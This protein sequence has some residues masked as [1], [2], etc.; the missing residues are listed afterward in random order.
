[1]EEKNMIRFVYGA[2]GGEYTNLDVNSIA[3]TQA[4]FH[5]LNGIFG[6]AVEETKVAD[7]IPAEEGASHG[8]VKSC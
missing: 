4:Q 2:E 3:S 8:A 6:M 1:M 5:L 7:S